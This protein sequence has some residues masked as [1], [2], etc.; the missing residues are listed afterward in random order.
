M[1]KQLVVFLFSLSD[2][3]IKLSF[4]F[5]IGLNLSTSTASQAEPI[6]VVVSKPFS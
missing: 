4:I 2:W 1:F 6:G 5:V 3:K